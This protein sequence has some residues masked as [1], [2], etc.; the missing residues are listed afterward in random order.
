MEKIED[1]LVET[2]IGEIKDGRPIRMYYQG[3]GNADDKKCL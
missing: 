2:M 1:Y 3:T